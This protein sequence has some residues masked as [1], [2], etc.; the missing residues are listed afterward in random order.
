MIAIEKNI[1]VPPRRTRQARPPM[2][3]FA[4]MGVG[5]SFFVKTEPEKAPK[6]SASIS[7]SWRKHAK[8]KG[9]KFITLVV[10]GGVRCWRTE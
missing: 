5:D 2:Y 6:K 3:P 4:D 7:L 8:I 9:A 1:P 10:D